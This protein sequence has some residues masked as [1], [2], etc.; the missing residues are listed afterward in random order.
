MRTKETMPGRRRPT[1][2]QILVSTQ[3]AE[4][5][6][7]KAH[8]RSALERFQALPA[9]VAGDERARHKRSTL[10]RFQ[11]LPAEACGA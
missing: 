6:R 9:E 8:K 7:H 3:E 5:A 4:R 11:A 2:V 1:K 10:E